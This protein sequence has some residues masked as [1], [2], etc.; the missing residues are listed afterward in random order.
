MK[1]QKRSYLSNNKLLALSNS[2][3]RMEYGLDLVLE[4]PNLS[5]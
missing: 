2:C 4:L 5:L 1:Y 3:K